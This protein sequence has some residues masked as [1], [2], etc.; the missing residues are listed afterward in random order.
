VDLAGLERMSPHA[1]V[2]E[3]AD[4][5]GLLDLVELAAGLNPRSVDSDGDGLADEDEDTDG[6]GVSN[7]LALGLLASPFLTWAHAGAYQP[8]VLGWQSHAQYPMVERPE[9]ASGLPI[10]S[11]AALQ[12]QGFF[13]SRLSPA[14]LARALDPGFSL[15]AR[16]EPTTGLTSVAIDTSPVGPRFDMLIR[17]IDDRSIEIRL[18][19]SIVPREGASVVVAAPIGGRLPVL[20]LRYR[21]RWHSASLYVDGRRVSEGYTGNR[22]FQDPNQ[23][24]VAWGVAA[25]GGGDTRAAA[26]FNLVWLEIF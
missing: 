9:R 19:S 5:D 3:D 25:A 20:E 15:L 7:R 6:E 24:G 8:R 2:A 22:Q 4:G 14:H 18:L 12:S 17:R 1:S 26:A 13:T 10:W 16:V 21:S 11:I 23:G